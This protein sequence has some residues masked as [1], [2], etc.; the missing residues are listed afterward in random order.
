MSTILRKAKDKTEQAV[1][2][3]LAAKIQAETDPLVEFLKETPVHVRKSEF[4]KDGQY[5][6]PEEGDTTEIPLPC[7][8]VCCPKATPHEVMAYPVCEVRILIMGSVDP[9]EAPEGEDPKDMKDLHEKTVGFIAALMDE[10]HHADNLA[11]LNKPS[12]GDDERPVKDFRVF[13]YFHDDDNAVETDRMWIDDFTYL[14]HC[15]P[16]DDT[17]G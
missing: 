8:V 11:A 5:V 13:G 2:A 3:F 12:V 7:I 16:T 14:F 4:D 15:V 17:S 9:P 6:P 10:E 1:A